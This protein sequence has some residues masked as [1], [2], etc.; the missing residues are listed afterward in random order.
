MDQSTIKKEITCRTTALIINYI[1]SFEPQLLPK[2][3]ELIIN[4]EIEETY[5]LKEGNWVSFEFVNRMYDLLYEHT[6][7]PFIMYEIAL[8]TDELMPTS[9]PVLIF[10]S[11]RSPNFAFRQTARFAGMYERISRVNLLDAG[12][13]YVVIEEEFTKYRQTWHSFQYG[14]GL[15]AG[16]PRA[17]GKELVSAEMLECSFPL[18]STPMFKE[19]F[20]LIGDY[21]CDLG[22]NRL[23]HKESP[24]KYHG[25]IFNAKNDVHKIVWRLSGRKFSF[26]AKKNEEYRSLL[27]RLED[28]S[29]ELEQKEQLLNELNL[30]RRLQLI[31]LPQKAPSTDQWDVAFVNQPM[32]GVSG[33]FYDFYVDKNRLLGLCLFDVSGHGI[34]SALLTMLGKSII[35]RNYIRGHDQ[36]LA[37]IMNSINNE[38]IREL[39]GLENFFT[40]LLLRITMDRIEY[41]NAAHPPFYLYSRRAGRCIDYDNVSGSLLGLETVQL[42]YEQGEITVEDGDILLLVTDCFT[43]AEN[44]NG[45][46]YP[47]GRMCGILESCADKTARDISSAIM[48]DFYKYLGRREDLPDDA[49]LIIL[50]K[51]INRT[52]PHTA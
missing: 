14:R 51:R 43:D 52:E 41:V 30:A 39:Q 26:S 34:S 46:P 6:K 7:N 18:T 47:Q 42:Q 35:Y 20:H 40:G 45:I 24:L 31:Y 27:Q 3:R 32:I 38:L 5:L 37:G 19:N 9:I 29:R 21:L 50:K 25:T 1:K 28:D 8:K 16:I 44:Q 33:D 23:A 15:F 12:R 17:C 11:F 48:E 13:N 4:L 36:D 2:L 22:G 49:T 10:R